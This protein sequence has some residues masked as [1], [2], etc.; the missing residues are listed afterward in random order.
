MTRSE[1]TRQARVISTNRPRF[2]WRLLHQAMRLFSKKA[3]K[4]GLILLLCI[5]IT[6]SA[7]SAVENYSAYEATGTA[8]APPSP[9][10]IFGTDFLGRDIYAEIV[11]GSGPSLFVAIAAAFGS[12]I[13]GL[14][15]GVFAG[16]FPKLYSPVGGLGDLIMTFPMLPL[17]I[18]LG[19]L[20]VPNNYLIAGLLTLVMWP[21]VARAIRAQ[22]LAIKKMAFVDAARTS[23]VK[24]VQIVF[25]IIMPEVL[26]IAVAY[27]VI[28]VSL[29][30]VLTTA[31]EFLGVGNPDVITWGSILYWAQQFGFISGAWWWIIVPGG[32]IT[33]TAIGF[34]LIGFSLEEIFNP[35]LRAV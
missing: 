33:L 9:S 30:L 14:F 10:H 8:T 15:V 11:A 21:L 22:V 29:A 16:Y 7:S 20:F 12:V 32:F 4:A 19:S 26:S 31:L 27:F 2:L 24:D 6:L 3:P 28:N 23:G 13:I 35:R 25:K 5:A 18:L 34:A 1:E 17:L